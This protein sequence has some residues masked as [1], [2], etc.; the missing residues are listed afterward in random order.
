MLN[1]QTLEIARE[2][3]G[4]AGHNAREFFHIHSAAVD[5]KGNLYLGE[6]NN[7]QRV[8]PVTQSE[9]SSSRSTKALQRRGFVVENLEDDGQPG[10]V[11]QVIA[12]WVRWRSFDHPAVFRV[13][14]YI[15]DQHPDAGA[16]NAGHVLQIEQD[17][18]RVPPR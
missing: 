14:R 9:D 6:V 8:L 1:R 12:C 4:H 15:A 13:I 5:S 3:G 10:D 18:R 2:R 17:V 11:Q 16:V 7:G